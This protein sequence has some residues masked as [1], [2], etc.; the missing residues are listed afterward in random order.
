MKLTL[1]LLL[2]LLS[3][4][5]AEVPEHIPVLPIQIVVPAIDMNNID[6]QFV[7]EMY[8][9]YDNKSPI[10]VEHVTPSAH[11][12]SAYIGDT[13]SSVF[14][15]NI[16]AEGVTSYIRIQPSGCSVDVSR[17]LIGCMF[18]SPPLE[19]RGSID[20]WSYFGNYYAGEMTMLRDGDYTRSDNT[21]LL[22]SLIVEALTPIHGEPLFDSDF[23][24]AYYIKTMEDNSCHYEISWESG[25]ERTTISYSVLPD[26][27]IT[28][29]QYN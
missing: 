24:N 2:L 23:E 6:W 4:C 1:L 28:D 21:E 27:S 10:L 17:R 3:G 5:S 13:I 15:T 9:K 12:V 19:S 16:N 11:S 7:L 20:G 29:I 18:Y 26:N 8:N 14:H 25:E 22:R